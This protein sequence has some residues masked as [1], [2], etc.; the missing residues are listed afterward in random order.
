MRQRDGG[1]VSFGS[2]RVDRHARDATASIDACLESGIRRRLCNFFD[3][4]ANWLLRM[5][6]SSGVSLP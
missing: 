3:F 1:F 2:P 6:P 4:M 5:I